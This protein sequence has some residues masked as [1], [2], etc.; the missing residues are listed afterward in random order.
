M[1]ALSVCTAV[2]AGELRSIVG[3]RNKQ[4]A[5]GEVAWC[6]LAGMKLDKGNLRTGILPAGTALGRRAV[7]GVA[8]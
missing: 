5:P 6:G 7:G 8:H 3:R 1:R 4:P 2:M